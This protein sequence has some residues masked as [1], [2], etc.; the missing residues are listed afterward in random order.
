M[1]VEH[2]PD[3]RIKYGMY[4]RDWMTGK[5]KRVTVVYSKDTRTNRLAA[6]D[7]LTDRIRKLTAEATPPKDMTLAELTRRY[8]EYQKSTVKLSTYDRNMRFC[9][10]TLRI[11]DG[12]SL[13]SRL[14]PEYIKKCFD[15]YI[16]SFI[17]NLNVS[18]FGYIYIVIVFSHSETCFIHSSVI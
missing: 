4:Y 11:V 1:Y 6:Q 12:D 13:V 5:K 16:H 8:L 14:T 9:N 7:T 15:A 17:V 10:S 2:L 3:G 18:Y